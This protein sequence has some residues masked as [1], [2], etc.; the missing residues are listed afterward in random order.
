MVRLKSVLYKLEKWKAIFKR[1]L[2]H[3]RVHAGV[4]FPLRGA[5]EHGRE[6][7]ID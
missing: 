3:K 6:W 4:E 1:H 5:G 7:I 2:K